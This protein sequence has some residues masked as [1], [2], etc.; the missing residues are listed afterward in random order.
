MLGRTTLITLALEQDCRNRR[1]SLWYKLSHLEKHLFSNL[2]GWEPTVLVHF[3]VLKLYSTSEIGHSSSIL[4]ATDEAHCTSIL[5]KLHYCLHQILFIW[6]LLLLLIQVLQMQKA[7]RELQ[8]GW[9]KTIS[10]TSHLFQCLWT[11]QKNS[12]QLMAKLLNCN[13]HYGQYTP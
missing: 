9:N 2:R 8:T 6:A 11:D 13:T 3:Q 7:V 5:H 12:E 4:E 10:N 1:T